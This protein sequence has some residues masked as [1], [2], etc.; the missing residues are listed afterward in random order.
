MLENG[1][2]RVLR[3]GVMGCADIAIRRMLPALAEASSVR[4]TA[5]AS[6]SAEK[7]GR[8]AARF[9][10]VA[11]H[12]YQRLLEREDVNAVYMPLPPGLRHPW[13][14]AALAAGKHVLAEK[15]L[16]VSYGEVAD[17]VERAR[18]QRLV[19]AENF[20]FL[21]HSQHAA[22]ADM[23]EQGAIGRIQVLG[24]SFGVPPLDPG[25]YRYRPELG[26]GALLD[27]GVYPLRAAALV[28]GGDLE[29]LGAS[30]RVDSSTGVDVAGS[31]LLCRADGVPA[32][33]DF[34][35]QHGYRSTYSVWGS[36]GRLTVTRAFTP[37]AQHRPVVRLQQQSRTTEIR[38]EPD[39]QVRNSLLAFARAVR[40]GVGRSALEDN[41]LN[42]A[43]LVEEVRKVAKTVHVDDPR[44]E[45]DQA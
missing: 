33:L 24:A 6:R 22:V 40:T 32:Q 37:P 44:R 18:R 27:L 19:L 9:G 10:C 28:L 8:V 36:E 12:G 11:V 38:L 1:T 34:G 15:P 30:L 13:A 23:I 5:V 3:L 35:F 42:Q 26:G 17:L 4:L 39:D 14:A 25:S 16:S 43:R 20:M 41:M 2:D 45:G 21:H 7:A 29:V 31:A